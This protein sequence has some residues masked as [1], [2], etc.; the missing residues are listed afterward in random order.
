M[1][2]DEFG[3]GT[4]T[5]STPN[6]GSYSWTV[7]NTLPESDQYKIL[8]YNAEDQSVFGTSFYF[9]IIHP[10]DGGGNGDD[11]N[12]DNSTNNNTIPINP[13]PSFNLWIILSIIGL[14]LLV[15]IIRRRK[16]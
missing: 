9:S 10:D 15:I 12:D 11:D 6:D 3:S 7:G 4:I 16:F 1:L 14:S 8:I 5:S 2:N 13:I